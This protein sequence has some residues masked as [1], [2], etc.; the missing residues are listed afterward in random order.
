MSVVVKERH[1]CEPKPDT[2]YQLQCVP[3][4]KGQYES[5]QAC[6]NLCASIQV[7]AR[8]ERVAFAKELVAKLHAFQN[9][10]DY[11]F[12]FSYP[13]SH[14]YNPYKSEIATLLN[15]ESKI[16]RNLA[17]FLIDAKRWWY[18][19]TEYGVSKKDFT[20]MQR[21]V[22]YL[23]RCISNKKYRQKYPEKPSEEYVKLMQNWGRGN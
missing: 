15:D 22:T 12:V 17:T 9:D 14:Q 19:L 11:S 20:D 1:R 6:D 2:K 8:E 13:D 4:P 16:I 3:D 18:Q 23:D 21:I 7:P 5:K 10:S